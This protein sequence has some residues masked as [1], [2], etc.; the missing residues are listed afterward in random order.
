MYNLLIFINFVLISSGKTKFSMAS[1]T[2]YNC[3]LILFLGQGVGDDPSVGGVERG[4]SLRD[5]V[6]S[7]EMRA[8][9]V[10]EDDEFVPQ[11]S[12]YEDSSNDND[13]SAQ[14]LNFSLTQAL[15]WTLFRNDL[16]LGV[17]ETLSFSQN[18]L[19]FSENS[20]GFS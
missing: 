17:G 7:R 2:L 12:H 6:E 1:F 9:D 19:S 18:S 10:V 13:R 14:E 20:L 3:F 5:E 11:S 16:Q 8:E 15:F 4:S